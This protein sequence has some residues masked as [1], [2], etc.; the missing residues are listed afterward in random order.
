MLTVIPLFDFYQPRKL[1]LKRR[2]VR[3]NWLK[4]PLVCRHT[5]P[6]FCVMRALLTYVDRYS[7]L[8]F[9][10]VKQAAIEKAALEA[11]LAEEAA[12]MSPHLLICICFVSVLCGRC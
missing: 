7:T 3:L 6:M 2:R 12:G 5:L 9:L 8:C 10:P 11:K 1:Q 4:R